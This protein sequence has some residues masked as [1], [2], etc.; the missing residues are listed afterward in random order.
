LTRSQLGF[1]LMVSVIM[2]GLF[3]GLILFSDRTPTS[4][5][6]RPEQREGLVHEPVF[7]ST[8]PA[9]RAQDLAWVY[10][11]RKDH[12]VGEVTAM[13][14]WI[15]LLLTFTTIGLALLIYRPPEFEIPSVGITIPTTPLYV[16][17]SLAL[18]YCWLGFGFTLQSAL[19]SRISLFEMMKLLE[20]AHLRHFHSLVHTLEGNGLV[21]ALAAWYL[22][23]NPLSK[24]ASAV[25]AVTLFG[26]YA[27]IVAMAHFVTLSLPL[28]LVPILRR[29]E[30]GSI[31]MG[32]ILAMLIA[33]SY[34]A[35]F[36]KFPYMPW[37]GVA[38][39]LYVLVLVLC[40]PVLVRKSRRGLF[41]E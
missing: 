9:P 34:L 14:R 23:H 26:V 21:D 35:F 18:L 6:Q 2:L 8:A 12:Y 31:V 29:G 28:V 20:P 27:L 41:D 19:E 33:A 30:K 37:F 36:M 11:Q 32:A 22:G 38:V 25:I 15:L 7:D 3:V 1:L 24:P 5:V 17:S 40:A 10:E 4:N 13:D 39:W 16:C